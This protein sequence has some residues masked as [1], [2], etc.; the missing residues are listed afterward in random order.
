MALFRC[1]VCGYIHD[2]DEAPTK[3]PKC[4]AP[5]EQFSKLDSEAENKILK[6]R[7]TNEM[8]VAIS[9]LYAKI[10]KWAK[11]IKEENLDPPC[12]AIADRVLK[13][14]TETIQAIKAELEGHMKKGKWG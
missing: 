8:H 2:G 12:V 1:K 4:G 3:C 13:D 14:T 7:K 5:K 9:G 11:T 10:Q 6:S